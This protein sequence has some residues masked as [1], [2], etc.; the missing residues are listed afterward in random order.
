[1]LSLPYFWNKLI[2]NAIFRQTPYRK[3]ISTVLSRVIMLLDAFKSATIVVWK[4]AKS[5]TRWTELVW[6]LWKIGSSVREFRSITVT[7]ITTK[8]NFSW[9]IILL[10]WVGLKSEGLFGRAD[11]SFWV[12]ICNGRKPQDYKSLCKRLAIDGLTSPGKNVTKIFPSSVIPD[13]RRYWS[14]PWLT[15]NLFLNDFMIMFQGPNLKF[16][17]LKEGS[18]RVLNL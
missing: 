17:K 16:V 1:M 2:Q 13:C 5:V 8:T 9:N 3:W 6:I 15:T 18:L 7:L 14:S 11:C 10:S 12:R 4:L